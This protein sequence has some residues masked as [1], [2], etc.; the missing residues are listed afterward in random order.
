MRAILLEKHGGPEVLAPAVVKEPV[1]GRGEV[2]VKTAYAGLNYA[3][4]LS[5][6][7]LYGW[8][9]KL[10][11]ILGMECSGIVE[12][13]GE[14]VDPSR[15][16]RSVMVGAKHGAYAEKIAVPEESAVPLAPGFGM[17]DG[18]SFL[19]NYMTAW[20]ALF[21][22]AKIRPGEKVLVTAAA[23]GVG[24]AAAQLASR[25]GCEVYGMA[26]SREKLD[27]IKSLGA[28]ESFNYRNPDC[29]KELLGV[30]GGVDAVLEVVGGNV[31]KRSMQVL[32]PFGRVVVTGF[33]SL[34]LNRRNP[35][36]WIKTWRD[37]P[38]VGV[39]ELARGS[40][41]VMSFHLGHLLDRE[42]GRMELIYSELEKFVTEH[43]IKPVI[44][45]VFPFDQAA[46]A[47]EYVESRKSYG[48]V[49]LRIGG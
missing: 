25:A 34:D 2:L 44:G 7:G 33:A 21:K 13:V 15:V 17:E 5:R 18:A 28:A 30:S 9:P 45:K 6:K 26:G 19:V 36:S 8:A 43:D 48:K 29:F 46:A 40:H 16:G 22:M 3:E 35:L 49:L 1:P 32:T 41:A 23:G 39:G 31:F 11:Y 37:I 4:I 42:P 38:R 14:G 12:Q 24:T 27:L 47:H 20:V 10:P